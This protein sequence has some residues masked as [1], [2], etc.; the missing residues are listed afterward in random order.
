MNA[1]DTVLSDE[2]IQAVLPRREYYPGEDT[3]ILPPVTPHER[4]I[5]EEGRRAGCREA[6]EWI[7]KESGHFT[8]FNPEDLQP[9]YC[10]NCAQQIVGVPEYQWRAQKQAWGIEE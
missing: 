10:Q 8:A 1:R 6:V 5:A 3:Y 9:H 7:E 4:A 2:Q